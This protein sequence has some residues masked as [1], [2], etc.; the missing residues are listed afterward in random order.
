MNASVSPCF[1]NLLCHFIC[2]SSSAK[3]SPDRLATKEITA[4]PSIK[5]DTALGSLP[6]QVPTTFLSK[7]PA[8][9]HQ[10]QPAKDSNNDSILFSAV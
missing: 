5:K 9:T 6:L 8:V 7:A 10:L 3:I 4:F 1:L 2:L